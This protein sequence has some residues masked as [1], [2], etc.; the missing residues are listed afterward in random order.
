M[1]ISIDAGIVLSCIS[2]LFTAY[3]WLIQA[4][5]ERPNLAFFQL[6]NFRVSCRRNPDS[7]NSKRIYFQQ[8][9]PGGVLIVNH[10]I[11]QNS[12]VVFECFLQT[13][14]GE[15]AGEWGYGGDDQPPW[16]V[17]PESTIA[18]SPACI[19]DVPED[20]EVPDDPEVRV[21]FITASGKTFTHRFQKDAPRVGADKDGSKLRAAA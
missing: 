20:F 4:R 17:G 6:A 18:F 7:E 16:N 19:F 9:H 15:I 8:L 14:T 11:R 21:Q 2:L 12:I 3:F 10:S 5:K 1:D 13:P